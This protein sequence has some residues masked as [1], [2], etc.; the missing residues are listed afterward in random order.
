MQHFF[1]SFISL[2]TYCQDCYKVFLEN[3]VEGFV[4]LQ[5]DGT[6]MRI[7]LL[8]NETAKGRAGFVTLVWRQ[9]VMLSSEHKY[10]FSD[11]TV[12][13]DTSRFRYRRFALSSSFQC[14]RTFSIM[15]RQSY[16]WKFERRPSILK[17]ELKCQFT[18]GRIFNEG[19]IVEL[20][21][22]GAN[23]IFLLAVFL[24][25]N[26]AFSLGLFEICKI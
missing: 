25:L 7:S 15:Q 1:L 12:Q 8:C 26:H 10:F 4:T 14:Y 11:W 16:S 20:L 18:P 19:C 21:S 22:R 6:V 17:M 13:I 3:D 5:R 23:A 9:T 24:T 2:I